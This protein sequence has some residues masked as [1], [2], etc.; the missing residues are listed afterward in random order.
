MARITHI[1]L[2]GSSVRGSLGML[3]DLTALQHLTLK[4]NE[5]SGSI[6]P[7]LN[8]LTDLRYLDLDNNDL[9]GSIPPLGALSK[10]TSLKVFSNALR[11][12]IPASLGN[13]R[14]LQHLM[15][16][17]NLL[18]GS[19]PDLSRLTN[20][21]SLFAGQN[22]LTG[23]LPRWLDHMPVLSAI[24]FFDNRLDSIEATQFRKFTHWCDLTANPLPCPLPSL[25]RTLCMATSRPCSPRI[26]ARPVPGNHNVTVRFEPPRDNGGKRITRFIVTAHPGG[27]RAAGVASPITVG[28]LKNGQ[29]GKSIFSY[30]IYNAPSGTPWFW[31]K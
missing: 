16:G 30:I 7:A 14:A 9:E 17:N 8:N 13:L 6:P 11:G 18:E 23:A 28:G 31:E 27:A 19:I 22:K 20:L 2:R 4:A 24:D 10:L 21:L 29:E 3:V 5:M 1:D 15:I 25:A 26:V 12:G